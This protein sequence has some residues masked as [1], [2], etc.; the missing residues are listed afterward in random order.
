MDQLESFFVEG[1]EYMVSKLNKSIYK[2]KQASHQWYLKLNDTITFF[3]VKENI[4]DWC[5][6]MKNSESL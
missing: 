5:I 6:Y 4:I 1:K 3:G 2:L